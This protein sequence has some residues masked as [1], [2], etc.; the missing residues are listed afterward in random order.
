MTCVPLWFLSICII[1]SAVVGGVI[2]VVSTING[3]V[4]T[5]NESR[6]RNGRL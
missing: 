1:V 5:I 2:G 3:V 6:K 4:S